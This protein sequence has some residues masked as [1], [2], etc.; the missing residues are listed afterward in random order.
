MVSLIVPCYN[1]EKFIA[2][3][4]ESILNQT[5]HN[6]E[7]ILVNDGSMDSTSDIINGYR[8]ELE[9]T[10]AKFIYVNSVH[11]CF[12]FLYCRDAECGVYV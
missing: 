1:G 12:E 11:P 2:R 7:L 3:C 5:D 6:I 8:V 4:I 10:L 9:N